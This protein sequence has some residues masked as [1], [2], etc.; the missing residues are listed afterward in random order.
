MTVCSDQMAADDD[1]GPTTWFLTLNA[2]EYALIL[3]RMCGQIGSFIVL[4]DMHGTN[5]KFCWTKSML[6]W[7]DFRR[8]QKI[9]RLLMIESVCL[10]MFLQLHKN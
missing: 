6:M 8:G 10:A 4:P 7:K 1:L 3:R 2:A 5:W 9:K